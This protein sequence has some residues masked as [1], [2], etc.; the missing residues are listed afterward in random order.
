[1]SNLTERERRLALERYIEEVA[2]VL[3]PECPDLNAY[4]D[5]HCDLVEL[6]SREHERRVDSE[7]GHAGLLADIRQLQKWALPSDCNEC[8]GLGAASGA[9]DEGPC[10]LCGGWTDAKRDRRKEQLQERN[11]GRH[12]FWMMQVFEALG[13]DLKQ[14][15][16]CQLAVEA[17]GK[18]K[19]EL[20]TAEGVR[21]LAEEELL[22]ERARSA[23]NLL[24]WKSAH[25]RAGKAQKERTQLKKAVEE[26][27]DRWATVPV[28]G[29]SRETFFRECSDDLA[30]IL[31]ASELGAARSLGEQP[32]GE[33]A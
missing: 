26:L 5:R 21:L 18:L 20:S 4:A 9:P 2:A 19:A 11:P 15:S 30:R 22:V 23:T 6:V 7:K 8:K 1:M 17:I 32:K 10:E 24:A 12:G 31:A 16:E 28:H 25:G 29:C 3:D 27:R 14:F 33:V 13:L